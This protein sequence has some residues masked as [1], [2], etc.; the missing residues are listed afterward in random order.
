MII[1]A[2]M[3]AK[4]VWIRDLLHAYVSIT[5]ICLIVECGKTLVHD[6]RRKMADGVSLERKPGSGKHNKKDVRANLEGEIAA[7]PTKSMKQLT[8]SL[9][10]SEA[11]V[12][13][14]VKD[15]NLSH[16]RWHCQLLTEFSKESRLDK[17]GAGSSSPGWST[18]HPQFA[19]SQTRRCGLRTRP[20]C[21]E[22]PIFAH[23]PPSTGQSILQGQWCLGLW[24][25]TA[26][27]CHLSGLR[28]APRSTSRSTCTSW[29]L[30]WSRGLT[31]TTATRTMSGSRTLPL[32]T[33]QR[34]HSNGAGQISR[35]SGRP[36]CGLHLPP[37]VIPLTMWIYSAVQK[38]LN[39]RLRD[40]NSVILRAL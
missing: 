36:T 24:H 11:T 5:E 18:T 4:Y 25:L 28:Q 39:T 34:Q 30:L 37:T 12:C 2:G 31:S 1:L 16:V 13:N 3:K 35:P 20:Q 40:E 29:R 33:R 10:V 17:T 7:N 14:Y 22:W 27:R 23:L 15:L 6:V 8:K 21:Q 19:S 26:G 9:N 32:V 38:S